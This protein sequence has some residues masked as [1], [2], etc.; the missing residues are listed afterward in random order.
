LAIYGTNLDEF[1]MIRVAGLK[2][3]FSAGVNVSGADRFTPL[4]QLREIRT[5]LHNVQRVVEECLLG[6]MQRLEKEG[7][8]FKSYKELTAQQRHYLDAYFKENIYPVIVPIAIDA[9]HPFP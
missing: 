4:H 5:Y 9:T 3:L 8:F 2:K 7:I 6:I 1:Y